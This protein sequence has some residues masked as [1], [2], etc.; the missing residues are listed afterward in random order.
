MF[1]V[2]VWPPQ[3]SQRGVSALLTIGVANV[4]DP[5]LHAGI[6]FFEADAAIL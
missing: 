5:D 6:E 4:G 3:T 2:R 1:S